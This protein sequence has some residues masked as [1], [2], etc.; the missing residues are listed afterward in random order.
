MAKFEKLRGHQLQLY[1]NLVR[2]IIDLAIPEDTVEDVTNENTKPRFKD[3]MYWAYDYVKNEFGN[4][5]KLADMLP[6]LECRLLT[7]V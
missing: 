2:A 7:C 4:G 3:L 1:S 5:V 6:D